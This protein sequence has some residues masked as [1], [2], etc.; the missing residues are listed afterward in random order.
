MASKTNRRHTVATF[1][2]VHPSAFGRLEKGKNGAV[3][4]S[5][6]FVL[7]LSET[8][9]TVGGADLADPDQFRICQEAMTSRA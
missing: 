3:L 5:L 1:T 7:G 6:S 2:S 8:A 4:R 9:T